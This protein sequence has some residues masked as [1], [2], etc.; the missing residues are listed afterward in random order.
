MRP[1]TINIF[2]SGNDFETTSPI[3]EMIIED[4]KTIKA[5]VFT[6]EIAKNTIEQVWN[7]P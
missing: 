5:G 2:I 6:S 4:V 7:S 3:I 1:I